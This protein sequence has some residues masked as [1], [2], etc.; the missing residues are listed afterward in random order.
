V[1]N[2]GPPDS[3]NATPDGLELSARLQRLILRLQ[4]ECLSEDGRVVDYGAAQSSAIFAEFRRAARELQLVEP[5]LLGGEAQRRALFINLYN[6][7]TIHG[8][9]TLP[10]LPDSPQS[11]RDFWNSTAYRVGSHT[12]TLNDIEHGILRDNG[13]QPASRTTHW[14]PSDPRA[15]LALPLDARVHFALN[16]GA[17]SCPPIRV[18]TPENIEKGLAAAAAGF[19]ESATEVR[20]DGT[21]VLS[22]LLNW[23]GRDFGATQAEVL[24]SISQMM[25]P[26][27]AKRAALEGLLAS[28]AASA[29]PNLSNQLWCWFVAPL[30]PAFMPRG[31]VVVQYAPYDWSLNGIRP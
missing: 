8:I 10:K 16:C 6:A 19:L 30:L 22:S 14:P 20:D 31:G 2:E 18:Y 25:R 26:G 21:V 4:A 7:L 3:A 5:E 1:L 27:S 24:A 12:L 13:I 17:R 15:A 29:Q 11:V 9:V 23:Y 28:G